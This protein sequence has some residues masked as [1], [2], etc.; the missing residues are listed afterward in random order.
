[1]E[2]NLHDSTTL[3]STNMHSAVYI[4]YVIGLITKKKFLDNIIPQTL[5]NIK[6]GEIC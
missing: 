5:A 1:M 3:L 2:S 4:M 6:Q